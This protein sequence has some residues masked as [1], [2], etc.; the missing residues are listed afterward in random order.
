MFYSLLYYLSVFQNVNIKEQ[1]NEVTLSIVI[2]YE[3]N[4]FVPRGFKA[5]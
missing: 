3:Q 4:L 2:N 1:E 5:R